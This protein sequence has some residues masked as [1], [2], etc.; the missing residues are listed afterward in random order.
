MVERPRTGIPEVPPSSIA[1]NDQL[2]HR[3]ALELLM[4]FVNH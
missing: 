1:D 3:L 2:R 4:H